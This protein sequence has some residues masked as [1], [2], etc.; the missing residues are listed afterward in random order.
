MIWNSPL[1]L[2]GFLV[3]QM[4]KKLPAVQETQVRSWIRKI[5][6]RRQPTPGSGRSPGE[7]NPLQHSC[8]ENPMDEGTWLATVHGVAESDTTE[9]LLSSLSYFRKSLLTFKSS[10]TVC[11]TYFPTLLLSWSSALCVCVFSSRFFNWF[12]GFTA[13]HDLVSWYNSI[14]VRVCQLR[15]FISQWFN[16]AIARE[17]YSDNYSLASGTCSDLY[18]RKEHL[19]DDKRNTEDLKPTWSWTRVYHLKCGAQL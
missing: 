14:T 2:W 9:W 17:I 13:V 8:L 18:G 6:W 12:F 4:V 10:N 5:P 1:L 16:W 19:M 7:G 11:W 15:H 3:A